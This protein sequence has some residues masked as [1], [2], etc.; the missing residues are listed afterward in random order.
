MSRSPVDAGALG[1][2]FSYRDLA[3]LG[4][5]F[6]KIPPVGLKIVNVKE[7]GGFWR[8]LDVFA[9]EN[10]KMGNEMKKKGGR[11][12]TQQGAIISF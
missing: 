1:R 3:F 2:H 11:G 7:I 9:P 5:R 8:I 4:P 12:T 10:G 6:S